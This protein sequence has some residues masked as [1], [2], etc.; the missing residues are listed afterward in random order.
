MVGA[1]SHA[2]TYLGPTT[3]TPKQRRRRGRGLMRLQH[4]PPRPCLSP[5]CCCTAHTSAKWSCMWRSHLDR[6][7]EEPTTF[8]SRHYLST[9]HTRLIYRCV[10][11]ACV[12][13]SRCVNPSLVPGSTDVFHFF[14]DEGGDAQ[15]RACEILA[16]AALCAHARCTWKSGRAPQFGNQLS[17]CITSACSRNY[18]NDTSRITEPA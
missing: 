15:Q 13:V 17:G 16:Q 1:L 11:A 10:C 12:C 3:T 2:G 6:P 5:G 4:Q 9:L 14:L 18:D 8:G 7:A